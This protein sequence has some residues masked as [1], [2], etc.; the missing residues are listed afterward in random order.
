MIESELE[1]GAKDVM[2]QIHDLRCEGDLSLDQYYR[3]ALIE[4]AK[5]IRKFRHVIEVKE[6]I[7][8]LE[9]EAVRMQEDILDYYNLCDSGINLGEMQETYNELV[10]R[11][12]ELLDL[13]RVLERKSIERQN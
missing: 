8:E 7:T 9:E 13:L 3:Q 4:Y 1:T 2:Q 5:E 12:I 11:H 10:E 6:I